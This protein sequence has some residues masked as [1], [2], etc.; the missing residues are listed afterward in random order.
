MMKDGAI[1]N[2]K[3]REDIKKSKYIH[4]N[5]EC[6]VHGSIIEKNNGSKIP[7]IVTGLDGLGATLIP[8]V[9]NHKVGSIPIVTTKN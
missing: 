5:E 7:Y 2:Q 9:S 3:V 6:I 1:G 8:W 4:F